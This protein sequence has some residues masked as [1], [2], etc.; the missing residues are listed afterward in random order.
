MLPGTRSERFQGRQFGAS[1]E[2][3][4]DPL[5]CRTVVCRA[6]GAVQA[7]ANVVGC[8]VQYRSRIL[9]V[10]AHAYT[11]IV[12]IDVIHKRIAHGTPLVLMHWGRLQIVGCTGG[13][14]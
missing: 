5:P 13:V 8:L 9:V 7:V 14:H 3:H 12:R 10:E 2:E 4:I 1:Q 11:P 6:S